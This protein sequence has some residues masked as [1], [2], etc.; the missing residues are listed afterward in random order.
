MHSVPCLAKPLDEAA[1][2]DRTAKRV[3]GV[4]SLRGRRQWATWGGEI[5]RVSGAVALDF[6]GG[7]GMASLESRVRMMR[8]VL[9]AADE[10]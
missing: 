8:L 3:R 7:V 9:R 6:T 2:S 5:R 1:V 4:G 10:E